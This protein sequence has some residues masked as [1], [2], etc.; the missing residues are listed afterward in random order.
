MQTL[1]DSVGDQGFGPEEY[2]RAGELFLFPEDKRCIGYDDDEESET[3]YDAQDYWD[4]YDLQYG[5]D[6]EGSS[7][8]ESESEGEDPDG[9]D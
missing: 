5:S 8:N 3:D 9:E 7:E 6:S 4:Y 2:I 1:C